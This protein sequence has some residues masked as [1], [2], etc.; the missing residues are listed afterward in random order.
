MRL[1]DLTALLDGWYDPAWAEAWDRVGLVCGDP[2]EEVR[3]VMFAVDPVQAVV[4]EALEFG[5]DLLV[6][7]HP[8]FLTPVGSVA[9]TTAKGR[10]VHRLVREGVALFTAHTNA[11]VPVDGTNDAIAR[12]LGLQEARVLQPTHPEGLD[13]LVVFVPVADA[14][15]VREALARAGAGAIGAYD[16]CTFTSRGE[17]R[18]RPLLGAVPAVGTVGD[19]EV[20]EECRVEAVLPRRLRRGVVEAV[21]AAHPYEEPAF[22]LVE[23]ADPGPS[24]TGQPGSGPPGSGSAPPARGHGRV[25]TLPAATTVRGLTA[26]VAAAFP[27]TAHGVRV[28]GDPD[29]PVST[30]AVGAGS[31]ESLLEEVRRSGADAYVTS[32]LKHHRASEFLEEGGPALLDVAHWAAEWLWLPVVA[33][34]VTRAVDDAGDTVVVRVS[35]LVTDPWTSRA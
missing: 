29:R 4:D 25:G 17:G 20:V 18:F 16:S 33:D 22:D 11:D 35:E 14:G 27:A 7:H 9:A 24:R 2:A 1:A 21:R 12:A 23:L 32:D 19:L 10:L 34:K 5:A 13:K 30:V 15:R 31:G 26:Q 6:V 3:R 28:A 8:L